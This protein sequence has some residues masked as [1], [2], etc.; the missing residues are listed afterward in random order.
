MKTTD[1][2]ESIRIM[3]VQHK[4]NSSYVRV[5]RFQYNFDTSQVKV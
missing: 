2:F 5:W 3:S 4:Y 1:D